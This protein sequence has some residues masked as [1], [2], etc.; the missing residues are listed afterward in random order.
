MPSLPMKNKKAAD[1][2]MVRL[3]RRVSQACFLFLLCLWPSLTWGSDS[4]LS[5]ATDASSFP[6]VA[7]GHAASIIHDPA[8]HAVVAIAAR[9]LATDISRVTGAPPALETTVPAHGGPCVLV[10]TLGH[11][12]L[13]D[14]LVRAGKLDTTPLAGKWETFIIAVVDAPLPGI[15]RALVIAG[16]DRRGTAFGVYELAQQIGVSP[17]HWWSDVPPRRSE[18]LHIRAGTTVVGPPS[19]KYRGIFINDEDWGLQPWAARTFAP[20]EGGIGPKTYRRV[21][22]LLLR[23]KANTLWPAMHACTKPF[24]AFPE[25]ARLADEYAII[26][27]SSHAEPMLRNNVGEWTAPKDDYNYVAN[28]DGVLAYWEERMRTNGAF[29]NIYTLGMRGIHDSHM[30]GPKTDAERIATLEAIFAD[31]R[32][33]IAKHANPQ[34]ERVPQMF[35]AYK[36]V[37][38]LYRQG[39]RVPDDVTIVWPD[40]NF[41]YIRNFATPAER[42]ARPG[43]FG[44]YYHI[45]YLGRPL[46]YLWLNTTPPA[47]IWEEMHKAWEHGADR[48]WIVNVGDI[49]PMEISTEFFLQMAWDIDRWRADNLDEFL[50]AWAAREFGDAHATEIAAI[51]R[52]YFQLNFQRRPEHLQ[53]WLP[54]EEPRR[55]PFTAEEIAERNQRCFVLQERLWKLHAAITGPH[56]DAFAQL[57]FY[58]VLGSTLANQR[59]F[60][61]ESGDIAGAQGKDAR[62]QLATQHVNETVAGG[63]W[64]G[65]I[66]LEPADDDWKSMR[67]APWQPGL[68]PPGEAPR[69]ATQGIVSLEAES[70]DAKSGASASSWVVVPG[71]GRTGTGAVVVQLSTAA[72]VA[73]ADAAAAPRLD[74]RVTFARPGPRTV[75]AYLLPTHAISAGG[76]LRCAIALGDQPPQILANARR[77]GSPKWAEGVLANTVIAT[78]TLDVPAAGEHIV[79]FYGL[80]PGVVVDKLVIHDPAAPLGYLGPPERRAEE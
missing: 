37:L 47:L 67:I 56:A 45:S 34:V 14:A 22:E 25:N 62:L 69:T 61:G 30:V 68:I 35:C 1:R 78:A 40:D 41:G 28:R 79:H 42:A 60:R 36:E 38:D 4:I 20:E 77:D 76:D 48:I 26:M 74:Y 66:R 57:V 2:G 17:W 55:S 19:V 16:S 73:L 7:N 50:V 13:I 43:G 9:D 11:S 49:K 23:L 65:F 51:M 32:A 31:Q 58:P 15:D 46:A 39:L 8:D 72:S 54:K 71:L 18:S 10:G 12:A 80:E 53:W 59:Y 64:R 33:L 52:E 70:F 6:L 27:G 21:F 63:K 5:S 75:T 24:N 29:E 3:M 44:V